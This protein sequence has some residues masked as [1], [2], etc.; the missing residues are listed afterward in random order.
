[1]LE[2][3]V[4][5]SDFSATRVV[6]VPPPTLAEGAV[7]LRIELFAL[8]SNNITYAAMGEGAL[9]YWDFFPAPEGWGRPPCWGFATVEAS[10]ADQ[11]RPGARVYGY[12][13]IGTHLDVI[14]AHATA[15][16]FTD[17]ASHRR[18]K[19]AVYNRYLLTAA[20]PAYDADREAEQSLFRP[21]YATGWWAADFIHGGT[22]VPRTVV[23][24]SASA[25]TALATAHQLK[26][27]GE[28]D[29]VALTSPRN[30]DF[31]RGTGLYDRV[32]SYDDLANLIVEAPATFVD[33]LGRDELTASVHRT[34]GSALRR[35]IM[36]GAT[37]WAAKPG[38]IQLPQELREGVRPEFF[39]VPAYAAQRI[40][41]QGP[42]LGAG[43]V[44]DLRAF[45]AA[46]NKL[47]QPARLSGSEAVATS[48]RR[49]M[50]GVVAPNEGLVHRW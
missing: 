48:W 44:G 25:K 27:L 15:S 31:L 39:F 22:P 3:Q 14:A 10:N 17:D 35:S 34:L 5:K 38:G 32:L 16:G 26:R 20:D 8:T 36:I 43:M 29:L 4:G 46:S 7:R 9:G 21:L 49:L 33:F 2:F 13:P 6:E 24:S 19:A 23:I 11:V 47:V 37:D 45:Y 12:F 1:M 40:R 41:Q 28:V 50:Q 18:A 30:L 42:T